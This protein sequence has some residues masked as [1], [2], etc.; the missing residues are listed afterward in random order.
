[1]TFS[2]LLLEKN[3]TKSLIILYLGQSKSVYLDAGHSYLTPESTILYSVGHESWFC[4][5]SGR[6][7]SKT[8]APN[9]IRCLHLTLPKCL[10]CHPFISAALSSIPDSLLLTMTMLPQTRS[11]ASRK[12][13]ASQRTA[14]SPSK[15]LYPAWNMLCCHMHSAGLTLGSCHGTAWRDTVPSPSLVPSK[16][17]TCWSKGSKFREQSLTH[18]ASYRLCLDSLSSWEV[19]SCRPNNGEPRACGLSC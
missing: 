2:V 5:E 13:K 12:P 15:L 1:M 6:S 14:S 17:S 9:C 10:L 19:F 4:V 7:D 18:Y 16:L 11:P 3:K 8:L